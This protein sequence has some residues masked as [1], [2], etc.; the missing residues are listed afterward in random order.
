MPLR[1][2]PAAFRTP[3]AFA[4]AAALPL[5]AGPFMSAFPGGSG[6][7]LGYPQLPQLI[8]RGPD[9]LS[10]MEAELSE[11]SAS[12]PVNFRREWHV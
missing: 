8:S 11:T 3:P 12:W 1:V 2:P 10:L 4:A 7:A 6:K 5:P 9:V